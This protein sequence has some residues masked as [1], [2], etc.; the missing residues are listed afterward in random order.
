VKKNKT[1]INWGAVGGIAAIVAAI[2]AIVG[3][4][5]IV[6]GWIKGQYTKY[7][8]APNRISI[9]HPKDWK[10]ETGTGDEKV[11]FSPRDFSEE[12]SP[13]IAVNVVKDIG[14]KG[15]PSSIES[16]KNIIS[17]KVHR[18]DRTAKIKDA[19]VVPNQ[20]ATLLALKPAYK[21]T[22]SIKAKECDLKGMVVG[23][24]DAGKAYYVVYSAKSSE[25]SNY[26]SA[27]E[28]I[29]TSLKISN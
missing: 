28:K 9:E 18:V 10:I 3:A 6:D 24:M 4:V 17:E 15:L 29:I 22:Y 11:K 19:S 25:F 2:T 7:E 5:P 13:V 8:D 12:C 16:Y 23:R 1:K 21:L 14:I 27:A 26:L 20:P